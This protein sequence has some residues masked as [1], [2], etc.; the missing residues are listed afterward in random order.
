MIGDIVEDP[1]GLALVDFLLGQIGQEP[2]S[3]RPE[4]DFFAAI[5]RNMPF[6]KLSAFSGGN[7]T[8]EALD[9][10]LQ[11]VNSDL[12]P[13]QV[14]AHLEAQLEAAEESGGVAPH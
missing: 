2:L 8:L 12:G 14:K 1:R 5:F 11:L 9:G 13:G 4:D 3:R 6:K 10:L 7:L